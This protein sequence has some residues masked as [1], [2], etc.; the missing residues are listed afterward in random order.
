MPEMACSGLFSSCAMP[1]TSTPM[2]ASRSCRITCCCSDCSA[3]RMRRSSSICRSMASRAA[4]RLSTMSWKASRTCSSSSDGIRSANRTFRSPPPTR[5]GAALE[6][7]QGRQQ[8]AQEHHLRDDQNHAWPAPEIAIVRAVVRDRRAATR[9][10]WECR[11]SPSTAACACSPLRPIRLLGPAAGRVLLG[12]DRPAVDVDEDHLAARRQ[13]AARPESVQV[14]LGR[15][16]RTRRGTRRSICANVRLPACSW[17]IWALVGDVRRDRHDDADG[18]QQ[19]ERGERRTVREGAGPQGALFS[20]LSR[21]RDN[22]GSGTP[23]SA[24]PRARNPATVAPPAGLAG[25]SGVVATVRQA[26]VDAEFEAGADDAGLGQ[27]LQR[28]P[29][30]R[31]VALDAGRVASVARYSNAAMNSGR[32]SGYPE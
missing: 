22:S 14:L 32:Q 20:P 1:D 2:A 29:D 26:V 16:L 19:Q 30:P 13:L 21:G 31:R 8:A 23:A 9:R 10:S 18:R 12:H 15:R 4:R 11:R 6:A 7:A 24:N 5:I 27:V 3:T 28:R 17:S 25:R